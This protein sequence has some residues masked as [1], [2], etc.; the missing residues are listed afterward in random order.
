MKR[1]MA[2]NPKLLKNWIQ[3]LKD[4]RIV[5][6]QSDPKT[7]KL[8]YKRPVRAED[9]HRFL[10]STGEFN[11]EEILAAINAVA[12]KKSPEEPPEA[13]QAPQ[14]TNRGKVLSQTPDAIRKR[15]QRAA[16]SQQ[17]KSG[18]AAFGQMASHLQ[19]PTVQEEIEDKPGVS[20]NEQDVEAVF[21][22]LGAKSAAP[23]EQPPAKANEV[24][25]DV[26]KKVL[27]V[28]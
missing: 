12:S 21:D 9:I 26:L 18:S 16:S 22:M 23:A 19:K 24:P 25:E 1:Q 11:D 8:K 15:Q 14:P 13:P 27:K 17:N 4:S 5:A 20:F 10:D 2:A 28:D 6:M 7:G 3:Y